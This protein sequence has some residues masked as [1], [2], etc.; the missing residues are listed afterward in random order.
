MSRGLCVLVASVAL[1]SPVFG[2]T[3]DEVVAKSVAARGG[4]AAVKAIQAV[5]M[6][7][8]MRMGDQDAPIVVEITRQGALRTDLTLPEGRLTQAWDGTTAWGLAPG[9]GEAERLPREA[10]AQM[11]QQADLEGV[12]VDH[13]AK[14]HRV[15]LMGKEAANGSEVF[16]LRVTLKT[17]EVDDYLLDAKSFLPVRV[18]SKRELGGRRFEGDAVLGD[19]REVGGW[20]WPHLLENLV[21]GREERQRIRFDRIEVNPSIDPSR[22]APPARIR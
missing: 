7:G 20:Q 11:A 13:Q 21:R 17:G 5:R 15:E 14:G 22:F 1:V 16:R 2:Q 6:T 9:E 8:V 19:Y 4:L 12:L 3:A 10:A 18:E